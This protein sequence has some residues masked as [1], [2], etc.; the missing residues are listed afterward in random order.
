[1][2]HEN[3]MCQRAAAGMRCGMP[4]KWASEA[5]IPYTKS[6]IFDSGMQKGNS[7]VINLNKT[8]VFPSL[9]TFC[10]FLFVFAKMRIQSIV[11]KNKSEKIV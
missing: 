9:Y 8:R 6:N 1:M 7:L 5:N 4:T 2:L 11:N 3:K 10:V